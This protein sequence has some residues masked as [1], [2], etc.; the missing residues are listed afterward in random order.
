MRSCDLIE[1][2]RGHVMTAERLH[3]DDAPVPVLDPGRGR[4]RQGRLWGY[5]RDG[6]PWDEAAAPATCYLYSP[7]RKGTHPQR[8]LKDFR[9]VLHAPVTIHSTS[10]G[11]LA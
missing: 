3:G 1:A 4:T 8:H 6:R 10:H 2:L 9:G 7:D 5:V 11:S